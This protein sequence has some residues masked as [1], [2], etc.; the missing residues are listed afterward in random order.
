MKIP[1]IEKD[2]FESDSKIIIHQ[3][4]CQG[5]MN[6][7]IAKQI[8]DRYPI[9]FE[10]YKCFCDFAY[11][12]SYNPKLLGQAQVVHTENE[13]GLIIVNLFSQDKFGYDGACYTDYDAMRRGL[14]ITAER[15]N[16]T[17]KIGIPYLIGCCRGG[18]DWQI[19]SSM[20]EE[21]FDG[22]NVTFYRHNKG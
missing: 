20:I 9:V 19:V 14:E 17:D 1:I 15:F 8:R 16:K 18:G 10:Q 21:I 11:E 13:N 7:G 6:S 22:Y 5:K 3:V 12:N 4:N 2:I